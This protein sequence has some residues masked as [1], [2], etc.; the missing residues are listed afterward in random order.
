MTKMSRNSNQDQ[1]AFT[2]RSYHLTDQSTSTDSIHLNSATRYITIYRNGFLVSLNESDQNPSFYS[3]ENSQNQI[4]LQSILTGHAPSTLLDVKYGQQVDLQVTNKGDQ[5]YQCRTESRFH[6]HG[7]RLGAVVSPPSTQQQNSSSIRYLSS[8]NQ[9]LPI[10][11]LQIRLL[12]GSRQVEYTCII[13]D[14]NITRLVGRFNHHHNIQDIQEFIALNSSSMSSIPYVLQ[15][16]TV[17][18]TKI[19]SRKN[20]TIEEAELV[21][22]TIVQRRL[23]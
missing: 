15:T 14:S 13:Y 19:L 3:Y 5:D 23:E 18:G 6:G 9:N 20:E 11:Q 17:T 21:N 1:D 16:S 7:H 2:G 8:L 12:D 4:L 22:T 10:T